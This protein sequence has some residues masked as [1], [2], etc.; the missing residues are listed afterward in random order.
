MTSIT[1][2]QLA[3]GFIVGMLFLALVRVVV[4]WLHRP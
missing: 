4:N 3:L 1:L 2:V